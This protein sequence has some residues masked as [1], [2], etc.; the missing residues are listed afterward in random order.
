MPSKKKKKKNPNAQGAYEAILNHLRN[1]PRFRFLVWNDL[2]PWYH[3]PELRH[4]LPESNADWV[5]F[6]SRFHYHRNVYQWSRQHNLTDGEIERRKLCAFPVTNPHEAIIDEPPD[7]QQTIVTRLRTLSSYPKAESGQI[8]ECYSEYFPPTP[9]PIVR[10]PTHAAAR[11]RGPSPAALI[12]EQRAN[13]MKFRNAQ[14]PIILR[15]SGRVIPRAFLI[16]DPYTGD[17]D[18]LI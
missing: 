12:R 14:D 13:E 10:P 7:W 8:P 11:R 9:S 15:S 17:W 5:I 18:F 2:H 3:Q 1:P 4:G 16:E 6:E